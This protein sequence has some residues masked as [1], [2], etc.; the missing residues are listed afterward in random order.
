MHP[1]KRRSS[2]SYHV[3]SH[4][5]SYVNR[6]NV[7]DVQYPFVNGAQTGLYLYGHRV[8]TYACTSTLCRIRV[9][10]H[11]CY[12]SWLLSYGRVAMDTCM[13]R[14]LRL[15]RSIFNLFQSYIRMKFIVLVA[16]VATN[17]WN[18]RSGGNS[19]HLWSW[20]SDRFE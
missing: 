12:V 2:P 16:L 19:F 15:Q 4:E 9:C 20:K 10:T 14:D 5:Y 17:I 8:Y 3:Y 11:A 18:V 13:Q 6:W 1:K 7:G